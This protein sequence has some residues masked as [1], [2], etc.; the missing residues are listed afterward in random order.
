LFKPITINKESFK[1]RPE[2][3]LILVTKTDHTDLKK[4]SSKRQ[5]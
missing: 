4:I 1:Q 3:R 5:I 2:K